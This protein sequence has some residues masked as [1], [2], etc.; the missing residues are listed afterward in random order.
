MPVSTVKHKHGNE[1]LALILFAVGLLVVLSLVSYSA[2]DPCFSISGTGGSVRNSVGIIGAYL[3]DVLLHLFGLS[4]YLL[5]AFLATYAVFL[6]L[7]KEAIHP[8]LKKVGGVV[9]F[10]S[11]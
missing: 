2:T 1:I 7:R 10:V 11:A 3:S 9:L 6:M 5:P 4:S 8:P